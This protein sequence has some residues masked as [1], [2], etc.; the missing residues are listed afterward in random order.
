VDAIKF[1][2][3]ENGVSLGRYP[4]GGSFW[5]SMLRTRATANSSPLVSVVISEIMYHPN[6]P[7]GTNENTLLE[8]IELFNPTAAPIPLADTNG[9]W[10][11]DGGIGFNFPPNTT[12]PAGGTLL[13]VNFDPADLAASNAFR[14]AYG[15][16]GPEVTLLGPYSGKLGNRS[17]RVALEKPQYPDLPGES[18]S[19]VIL[20][21]LI[22]GNQHPWP[23]S[24]NGAGNSLRRLALTQS[25]DDP[26]NWLAAAPSPGAAIEG[27]PDRD[28]D[29]MPN[30]WEQ[31]YSLSPDDPA[32][33]DLDADGDGQSNL[34]EYLSGTNP[35]EASSR[36]IFDSVA[37]SAGMV[38]MRFTAVAN[39]SYTIQ[40]RDDLT[41]GGWVRLT[42]VLAGA[43]TGAADVPDPAGGGRER[44]YRLLTPLNP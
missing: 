6:D 43:T 44:Y 39:R 17:D 40:Y 27:N 21:E 35:R 5:H 38:T 28:G 33:A 15:V 8:Y 16:T 4:D 37:A 32:D 36:L 3:Q 30:D 20:D 23:A 22:Y 19:W 14:N 24:A 25:G 34:Q 11:L 7:T 2:G 31:T 42:N 26:S 18:Y 12:M 29:G 13:V 10:R 1:K 9:N 41:A